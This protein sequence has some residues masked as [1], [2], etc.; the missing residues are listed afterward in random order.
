MKAKRC[1]GHCCRGFALPINQT[2]AML[3]A[4]PDSFQ[5]GRQILDMLVPL[6]TVGQDGRELF[7]CKHNDWVT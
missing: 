3:A 6:G 1:T 5:D 2:H 7:N 4:A